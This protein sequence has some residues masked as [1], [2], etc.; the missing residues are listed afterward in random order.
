MVQV[1]DLVAPAG[2]RGGRR[3][4]KVFCNGGSATFASGGQASAPGD[5]QPNAGRRYGFA[6]FSP[7]IAWETT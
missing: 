5:G 7:Q 2:D 3:R 4:R 6:F 1:G